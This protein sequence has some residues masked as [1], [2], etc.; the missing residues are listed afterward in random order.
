VS[1]VKSHQ[2]RVLEHMFHEERLRELYFFSLEKKKL[3]GYLMV[4][5][6]DR[7]L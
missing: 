3:P 5:G 1:S 4:L 2:D 6:C 7:R